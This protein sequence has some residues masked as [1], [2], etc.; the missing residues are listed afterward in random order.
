MLS[1]IGLLT[2]ECLSLVRMAAWKRDLLRLDVQLVPAWRLHQRHSDRQ[3]DDDGQRHDDEQQLRTDVHQ[4]AQL[5]E[6]AALPRVRG[7]GRGARCG[8]H[9]RIPTD[10]D[11]PHRDARE[12]RD[13]TA[14]LGPRGGVSPQHRHRLDH[15]CDGLRGRPHGSRRGRRGFLRTVRPDTVLLDIL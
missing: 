14:E 1:S 5:A 7:L 11:H 3:L 9:G 4:V 2:D 12:R 6:R 15:I 8:E 10:H 13:R